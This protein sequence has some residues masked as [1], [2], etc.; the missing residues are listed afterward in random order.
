MEENTR[1]WVR[2][3]MLSCGVMSGKEI[4]CEDWVSDQDISIECGSRIV[5]VS[6]TGEEKRLVDVSIAECERKDL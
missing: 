3:D 5:H 6:W 1:Y 4:S 2:M